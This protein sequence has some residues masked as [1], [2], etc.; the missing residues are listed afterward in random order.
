MACYGDSLTFYVYGNSIIIE[1]H[2][3]PRNM[4]L[5]SDNLESNT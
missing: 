2:L 4:F 3:V 5:T 1:V